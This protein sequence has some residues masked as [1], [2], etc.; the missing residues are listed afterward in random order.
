MFIIPG[1]PASLGVIPDRRTRVYGLNRS[2]HVAE[3]ERKNPGN[4]FSVL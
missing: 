3:C 4:S 2:R 1:N